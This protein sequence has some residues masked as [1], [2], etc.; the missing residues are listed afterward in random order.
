MKFFIYLVLLLPLTLHAKVP[1][2][3]A[4]TGFE[5]GVARISDGDKALIGSSWMYHFDFRPDELMSFFGQAGASTAKDD[6]VRLS[7]TAFAGGIQLYL[8][9]VLSFRFGFATTITEIEKDKNHRESELG[10]LVAAVASIPIGVF[11]FGTSATVI[12]TESMHSTALRA[13]AFIS[14]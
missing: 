11:T 4:S 7:Q 12:R 5:A 10:P 2:P 1:L 3:N 9:P 8:L 6:D 13:F 14:F